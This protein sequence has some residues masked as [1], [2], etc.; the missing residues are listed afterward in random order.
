MATIRRKRKGWQVLIRKKFGKK[1]GIYGLLN[2]SLN[3]HG[4]P[5]VNNFRDAI[6]VFKKTDLDALIIILL[7]K[8]RLTNIS[9][10]RVGGS[11]PPGLANK[12]NIYC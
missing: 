12:C 8:E 7:L 11:N 5:L 4:K 10:P 1:S 9:K 3:I 2:T 6:N